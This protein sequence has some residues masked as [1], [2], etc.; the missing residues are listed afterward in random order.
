MILP[1]LTYGQPILKKRA[2]RIADAG[3]DLDGLIADMYETMYAAK[4]VGLAAPQIG[5]SI[6]LFVIDT[7]QLDHEEGED[8]FKR[9]FI[10]PIILEEFDEWWEYEE[11]CLSIPEIRGDIERPSKI[12]I[13]YR[14]EDGHEHEEVFEGVN[15]R[16]IQHEYD[17]LEGV[18]FTE[19]L[20]PIKKKLIQRKLDQIRKG[21]VSAD[22]PIKPPSK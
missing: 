5:K 4:G 8:G 15:A 6:R 16:V 22:Y 17:H 13:H 10:N 14:D 7:T 1:I 9:A 19:R 11:G 21:K 20:K 18:L 12:R 2:E 3:N